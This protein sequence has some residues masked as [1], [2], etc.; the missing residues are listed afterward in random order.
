MPVP[1]S[2]QAQRLGGPDERVVG[3]GAG[4]DGSFD[5]SEALGHG[6]A[7]GLRAHRPAADLPD[8]AQ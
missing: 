3:G 8:A 7:A 2:P 6:R 1:D 5:G 4:D